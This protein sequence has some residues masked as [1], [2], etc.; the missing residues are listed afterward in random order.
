MIRGSYLILWHDQVERDH[1]R[2]EDILSGVLYLMRKGCVQKLFSESSIL[3]TPTV[4]S[5]D[6]TSGAAQST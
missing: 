2:E 5:D 1:D 4:S 6:T 3:H